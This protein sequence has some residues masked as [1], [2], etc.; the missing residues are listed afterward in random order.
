MKSYLNN[1]IK[2]SF[3]LNKSF[4]L[5]SEKSLNNESILLLS[6]KICKLKVKKLIN[7][8]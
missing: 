6:A 3:A 5:E 7:M 1:S 2:F 8:K 4:F